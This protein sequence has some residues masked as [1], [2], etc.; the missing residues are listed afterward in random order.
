VLFG[1]THRA[2][3]RAADA[4]EE[5]MTPAGVRLHNA[6]CWVYERQFLSATPY[7]SPYWPG[8]AIRV[9]ATG[10]P[11]ALRVLEGFDAADLN[12]ALA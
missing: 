8:V 3:P 6:G 12:R 11:V 7:E 10:P 2:G 1:H 4:P 5:W 9:D